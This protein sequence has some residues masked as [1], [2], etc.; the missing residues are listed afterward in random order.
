MKTLRLT[1]ENRQKKLMLV[2]IEPEA[3]DFWLRPEEECQLVAEKQNEEALFEIWY[4]DEGVTVFPC[5]GCGSISVYQKGL[6]LGC[7][8]Q[9]PNNWK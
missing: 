5:N 8:H 1:I 2:F 9:R 6:E 3:M 4:T 7:G